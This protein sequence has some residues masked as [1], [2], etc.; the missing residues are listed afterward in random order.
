MQLRYMYN[1]KNSI[2][3]N[4]KLQIPYPISCVITK[5]TFFNLSI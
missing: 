3:I 5:N 4:I 1:F 2:T